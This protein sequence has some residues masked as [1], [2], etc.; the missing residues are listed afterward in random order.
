MLEAAA[1]LCGLE[2]WECTDGVLGVDLSFSVY[3]AQGFP[4]DYDTTVS[5]VIATN[6]T[7]VTVDG[8]WSTDTSRCEIEAA[9]G[10]FTVSQGEHHALTL[11]GA[12]ACDGCGEWQ[13]QGQ[14]TPGLCGLTAQ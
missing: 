13:V 1:S 5:G 3:P 10:M 11:N 9:N 6:S 7:P 4:H 12:L 14:P 2:S 8:A